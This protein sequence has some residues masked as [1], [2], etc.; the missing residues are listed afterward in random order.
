MTSVDHRP[1]RPDHDGTVHTR[2]GLPQE[3]RGR[4]GLQRPLLHR[5]RGQECQFWVPSGAILGHVDINVAAGSTATFQESILKEDPEGG[6]EE[7]QGPADQRGHGLEHGREADMDGGIARK[8]VGSPMR[9]ARYISDPSTLT[10]QNSNISLRACHQISPL[11]NSPIYY[12]Q[13]TTTLPNRYQTT[14]TAAWDTDTRRHTT[15]YG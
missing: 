12:P 13:T 1:C 6:T 2:K 7:T 14:S 8:S 4:W 3:D 9:P 11:E 15:I 5:E 10:S